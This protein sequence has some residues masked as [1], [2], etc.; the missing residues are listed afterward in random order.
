M[1]LFH[2]PTFVFGVMLAVV[3]TVESF[4]VLSPTS[5]TGT[6]T[7][8]TTG[9]TSGTLTIG[10]TALGTALAGLGVLGELSN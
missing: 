4:I 9:T 6:G 3:A 8:G 7:T 2:R 10:T 1:L 5:S